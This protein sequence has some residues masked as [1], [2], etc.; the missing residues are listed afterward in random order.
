MKEELNKDKVKEFIDKFLEKHYVPQRKANPGPLDPFNGAYTQL[1]WKKG[2]MDE[3]FKF[4]EDWI[5]QERKEA[6]QNLIDKIE[7]NIAEFGD[8]PKD[9]LAIVSETLMLWFSTPEQ[10][11]EYNEGHDY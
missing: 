10:I 4:L 9:A 2:V 1:E 6:C 8:N 5:K 7:D 3:V 11:R